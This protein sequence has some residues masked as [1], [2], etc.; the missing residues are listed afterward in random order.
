MISESVR[1]GLKVESLGVLSSGT[2]KEHLSFGAIWLASLY[3]LSYVFKLFNRAVHMVV[4][5]SWWITWSIMQS[6]ALS[7][8]PDWHRTTKFAKKWRKH[9]FDWWLKCFFVKLCY[10]FK[11][12]FK[13][14]VN[15]EVFFYHENKYWYIKLKEKSLKKIYL[16]LL[17][18]IFVLIKAFALDVSCWRSKNWKLNQIS[19]N[20]VSFK[21]IH[22]FIENPSC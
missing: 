4:L 20:L 8:T 9:Y 22:S 15:N 1:S 21:R 6:L 5:L 3:L 13:V 17:S 2:G 7:L 11:N 19:K 18:V 10:S 14:K 12:F 16:H